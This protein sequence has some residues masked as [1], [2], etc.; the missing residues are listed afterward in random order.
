MGAPD[1]ARRIYEIEKPT[2]AATVP[3]GDAAY[4]S[5]GAV[6]C[7]QGANYVQ[8]LPALPGDAEVARRIAERLAAQW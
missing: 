5:G 8:V 1:G 6:F 2:D 7:R 3:I 4:D